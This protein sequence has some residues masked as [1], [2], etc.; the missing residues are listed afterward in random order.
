M[1]E[2]SYQQRENLSDSSFVYH[3]ARKYPIHDISHARNALARVSM[4]GTPDEKERVRA[5]VYARFP[6]LKKRKQEREQT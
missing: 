6:G 2:L 5:A 4:F 3:G 1:A